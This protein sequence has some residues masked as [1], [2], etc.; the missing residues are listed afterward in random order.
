MALMGIDP[1]FKHLATSIKDGNKIY[2]DLQ[3]YN[4][5]SK[6]GFETI[7]H[8]TQSLW[9]MLDNYLQSIGVG[10]KI[11]IDKVISEVPPP[12]GQFSAGLYAL[13]TYILANLIKKYECIKEVYIVSPSYLTMVHGGK[14]KKSESTVLAKYF[15]EEVFN[16]RYELDIADSISIKGKHTK[17]KIN[18]D[19]AES[20]IFLLHLMCMTDEDGM[21]NLITSTVG[22]LGYNAEKLLYK[23]A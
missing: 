1:S 13:D 9:E 2:M 23:R 21:K 8:A 20:F 4:L 6:M 5:G 11:M 14:Y 22:G 10:N 3:T 16:N 17:G 12:I 15:L 18:N 7:F 19:K